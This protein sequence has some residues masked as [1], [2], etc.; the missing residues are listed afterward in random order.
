MAGCCEKG[1]EPS[2]SLQCGRVLD[3]LR[4]CQIVKKDVLH[5]VGWL[6]GLLVC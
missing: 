1:D 4:N 3:E 5:G 6:V 2:D